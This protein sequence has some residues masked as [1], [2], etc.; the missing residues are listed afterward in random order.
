MSW[1]IQTVT[2]IARFLRLAQSFLNFAFT[3][4][5]D[6]FAK[7]AY[8]QNDVAPSEVSSKGATSLL[9]LPRGIE[10]LSPP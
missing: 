2:P 7:A 1:R 6:K 8:P 4:P 5:S 10:P 9:V 3:Q